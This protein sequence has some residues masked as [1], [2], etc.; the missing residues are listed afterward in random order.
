[1][2]LPPIGQ[3]QPTQAPSESNER[4][5]G[6]RNNKAIGLK[7]NHTSVG[8]VY[9]VCGVCSTKH[10]EDVQNATL[11]DTHTQFLT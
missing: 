2:V 1:M 3:T 4:P 11:F 8:R 7:S 5:M 9:S 6:D 10:A